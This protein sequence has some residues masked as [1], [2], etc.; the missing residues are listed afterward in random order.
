M[1]Q[2]KVFGCARICR[3][4]QPHA[5]AREAGL[6]TSEID[7]MINFELTRVLTAATSFAIVHAN[8]PQLIIAYRCTLHNARG[9][10]RSDGQMVS[11]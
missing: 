9:E 5:R 3:C 11:M 1:G 8:I 6:L 7:E 4:A 2:R 10:E